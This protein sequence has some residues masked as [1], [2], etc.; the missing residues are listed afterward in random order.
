MS[1]AIL[2]TLAPPLELV[3]VPGVPVVEPPS[4]SQ[5][6]AL[7]QGRQGHRQAH[8]RSRGLVQV[9][10][11]MSLNL[12]LLAPDLRR[13]DLLL[14]LRPPAPRPWASPLAVPFRAPRA[15]SS[16]RRQRLP[17]Q[18]HR[19]KPRRRRLQRGQLAK[20]LAAR[21]RSRRHHSRPARADRCPPP[22]PSVG[23]RDEVPSKDVIARSPSASRSTANA[24]LS[25]PTAPKGAGAKLAVIPS[26]MKTFEPRRSRK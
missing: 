25:K 26:S 15:R 14:S 17:R 8:A 9:L 7:L 6:T 16:A 3:K 10:L 23:D 18:S 5:S 2:G 20:H 1:R 22:P 13:I 21:H 12:I 4:R 19:P 11:S 24:L